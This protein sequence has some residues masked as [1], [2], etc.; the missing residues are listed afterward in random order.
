MPTHPGCGATGAAMLFGMSTGFLQVS[1]S[2]FIQNSVNSSN[3]ASG[4]ALYLNTMPRA[5]LSNTR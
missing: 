2:S 4:G 3:Y 1:S 5:V